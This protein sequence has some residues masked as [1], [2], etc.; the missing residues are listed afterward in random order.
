MKVIKYD[1]MSHLTDLQVMFEV[2]GQ[3]SCGSRLK[4]TW[5]NPSLKIMILAGG[6]TSTSSCFMINYSCYLPDRAKT[7]RT[8]TAVFHDNE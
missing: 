3:R 6:L 1:F 8:F 2:K 4:V 5:V 7:L